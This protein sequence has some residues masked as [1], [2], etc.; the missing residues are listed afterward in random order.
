MPPAATVPGSDVPLLRPLL[1]WRR[2]ELAA[3]CDE[4][5]TEP[6]M[7]PS[8]ADDR[9]ERVRIRRALADADWIDVPALAASAAHLGE[10]EAALEW[11]TRREWVAAVTNGGAEIRYAPSDAPPEIRRRIVQSAVGGL[12]TEGQG[13]ELRGRELDRL[14]RALAAGEVATIRGVLCTGGEEWRFSKAPVRRR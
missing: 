12:A 14:M 3:I 4:A 7:D 6:A 10:A 2:S 11:A 1:E 9:F 8:N 13:A 5:G